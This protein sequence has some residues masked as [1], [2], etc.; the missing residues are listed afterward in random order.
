LNPTAWESPAAGA[1]LAGGGVV[2]AAA[3]GAEPGAAEQRRQRRP[4]AAAQQAAALHLRLSENVV[5]H[6]SRHGAVLVDAVGREGVRSRA[7]GEV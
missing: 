3:A 4:E 7:I 6:L 5:E 1:G 2:V